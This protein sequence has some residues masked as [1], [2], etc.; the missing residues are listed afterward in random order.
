[1]L[2]L[3]Q[4]SPAAAELLAAIH[5]EAFD[6]PWDAAAFAALLGSEGVVALVAGEAEAPTGLV[7][8][9]AVADEAE[10]LTLAVLPAARR[11]GVGAA[12]MRAAR[13]AAAARGARRLF[14]EVAEDN[15]AAA[16]LYERLGFVDVGRRR[17]YYPRPGAAA[18]AARVLSLDM[19]TPPAWNDWSASASRRACA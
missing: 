2:S 12:L 5:G 19:D 6:D 11:Q 15:A 9:R 7:V 13:E 16:S 18:A 3:T 1:M 17:G 14:L 8:V 10:I 4:A